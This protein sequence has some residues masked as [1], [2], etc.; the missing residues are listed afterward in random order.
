MLG[1]LNIY[2]QWKSNLKWIVDV[3]K[4]AKPIKLLEEHLGINPDALRLGNEFLDM[5]SKAQV[6]QTSSDLKGKSDFIKLKTCT[7]KSTIKNIEKTTKKWEK[8]F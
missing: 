8:I 7:S 4:R 3:Y 5:T 6:N 1:Q 2:L